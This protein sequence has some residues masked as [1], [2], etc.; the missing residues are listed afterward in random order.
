MFV[1]FGLGVTGRLTAP[2]FGWRLIEVGAGTRRTWRRRAAGA[3][4]HFPQRRKGA[5]RQRGK[6]AKRQRGKENSLDCMVASLLLCAFAGNVLTKLYGWRL[7][8]FAPL[9]ETFL[10]NCMVA[11][12][13]LCAFAGNVLTK[14][15]TCELATQRALRFWHCI[16]LSV[17]RGRALTCGI[18]DG[19]SQI[20]KEESLTVCA[21]P[22]QSL[23][24]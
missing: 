16:E 9:R 20:G 2:S 17:G 15:R 23:R 14:T 18:S 5:K 4:K 11:S 6:E 19:R 7:C 22:L 21:K 24:Y 13:L 1:E 12:L 10:Q 3:T 8:S